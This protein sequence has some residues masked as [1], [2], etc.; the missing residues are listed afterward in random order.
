MAG[1]SPV[2]AAMIVVG[3]RRDAFVLDAMRLARE[4]EAK[5]VQCHDVYSAVAELAKAGGCVAVVGVFGEMAREH[6]RFFRLVHRAG[7]PCYCLLDEDDVGERDKIVNAVRL[8]VH[9]VGDIEPVRDLLEAS[10]AVGRRVSSRDDGFP[11]EDD[12][13][14]EAELEALLEQETDG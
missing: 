5:S 8:G 10:L 1:D 3:G 6:G 14:T 13:A 4:Y 12:R 9:L 11:R 7:V 2:N